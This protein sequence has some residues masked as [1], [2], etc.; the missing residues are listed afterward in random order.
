MEKFTKV[1]NLSYHQEVRYAT[2]AEFG[3]NSGSE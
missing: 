3:F 2:A 1:H